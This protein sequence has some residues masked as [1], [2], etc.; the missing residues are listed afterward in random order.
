MAVK[1]E[2]IFI[3]IFFTDTINWMTLSEKPA[4]TVTW[5]LTPDDPSDLGR[6]GERLFNNAS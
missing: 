3:A 1:G 2:Q 5:H 4:V 6:E